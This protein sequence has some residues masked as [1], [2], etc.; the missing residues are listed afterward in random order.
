MYIC[1]MIFFWVL[2][3]YRIYL[4]Y[5]IVYYYVIFDYIKY[6]FSYDNDN[7]IFLLFWKLYVY[8]IKWCEK[9]IW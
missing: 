5:F 2:C 4:F 6:E 9:I 1:L 7:E 8:I 3:E